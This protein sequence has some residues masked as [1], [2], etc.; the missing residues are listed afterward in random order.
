MAEMLLQSHAGEIEL[1][2]AL[3]EE[4][5]GARGGFE[6]DF[7][8][9]EGKLVTATLKSQLGN[10]CTIRYGDKTVVLQTE[11]GQA[12]KMDKLTETSTDIKEIVP[13]KKVVYKTI[14]DIELILQVFQP[15]GHKATNNSPAV[16]FFFGGG[17]SRGLPRQFH[18]QSRF[19][20]ERGVVC[21]C[22][23]YRVK[24]RHDV[25]AV[26][27]VADAKSAVR[28]VRQ[29]AKELGV[30]GNQIVAA[31][32]STGGHIAACTGMTE[33]QD[34]PTEDTTVSSIPN[35]MILF[36]PVLDTS[37][38][39]GF[40]PNRN[41]FPEGEEKLFSPNHLVRKGIV[42][43]LLFHGTADETVPFE[44]ATQFSELMKEA[45]NRCDLHS[46]EG[47][48]HGFFNGK[49]FLP[50]KEDVEPYQVT[51]NKS[52]EFLVSLGFLQPTKSE[53]E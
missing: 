5:F 50:K 17:W 28:W 16:I 45:G 27:C 30:N 51:M 8:W 19:L 53:K 9:A 14:D 47:K 35:A 18:E 4:G 31:G 36:N 41:R 42:P 22:A 49:H 44:K 48:G 38:E 34:E 10:D 32:G 33:G 3:P 20:S 13:D 21:F 7:E 43:T 40:A 6:V 12:Y 26:E 29:H 46:F 25:T 37:S 15:D 1:L 39:T 23:N 11:T 24:L 2:P 52:Y